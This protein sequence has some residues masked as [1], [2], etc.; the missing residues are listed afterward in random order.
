MVCVSIKLWV[1]GDCLHVYEL[2]LSFTSHEFRTQ[3]LASHRILSAPVISANS[4]ADVPTE[5]TGLQEDHAGPH[6]SFKSVVGFI[7]IRDIL[8]SF[9]QE[10]DLGSLRDAKMLK[11]MRIL[12]D[13]GSRFATKPICELKALGADGWFYALRTAQHASLRDIVY[14][15][16]LYPKETKALFGGT[17]SRQVVH[18]LALFDS[19]GEL[20][21]VVSQSDVIS[22]LY[23]HVD[24]YKD[25]AS[26]TVSE[27]G[28]VR[29][30][31][32]V[33]TVRPETPAL[34]AMVLMEEKS[35]SAVAVV[36]SSGSI[37]GNFSI[38]ELRTIMAEHFGSLALP[39]GEFLALEHGTEYAGYAVQKE[40]DERSDSATST[41][42]AGSS[43][44][45][46]S[47]S[48][49]FAHDRDMRRRDSH[50]GAE[51]GQMLI[52][53]SPDSTL[54][55]VLDKLVHNRLHRVYVCDEFLSPCGVITLTDI[56]RKLVGT[57][58]D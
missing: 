51:V 42:T 37:I 41:P 36:N 22:F 14:D 12:E 52:T 35:I 8:A 2:A 18:R 57:G 20:T 54:A 38:S 9:L 32:R 19:S 34:D 21:N 58:T 33:L 30:Q 4:G 45:I 27:L 49:R 43:P 24:A 25:L 11:R 40:R 56:L 53:C 29:G 50:P 28:F 39:V 31:N 10:V 46:S 3:I 5:K 44:L 47:A 15:G 23:A 48:Y 55:E 16:F 17:R 7:D 26:S 13:N 1:I 6:D